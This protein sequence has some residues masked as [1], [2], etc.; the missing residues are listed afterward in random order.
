MVD[1]NSGIET[2]FASGKEAAESGRL[3]GIASG[4][5]RREKKKLR[6]MV[7]LFGRLK[8]TGKAAKAMDDLGIEK[9]LQTRFMQGVV[10]LFQKAS[11]GDVGAFN[12]IR[13]IIGEK[14][15]DETRMTATLDTDIRVGY[16]E[17]GI[18]PVTSEEDIEG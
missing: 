18:E 11:K 15:V 3:G 13:D 1:G 16:V 12:A 4:E 8:V 10:S 6:E 14:P 9:D 7:E 2:R 17:T 5:A